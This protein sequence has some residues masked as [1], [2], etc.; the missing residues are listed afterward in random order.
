MEKRQIRLSNDYKADVK[1]DKVQLGVSVAEEQAA[2][3]PSEG[4]LQGERAAA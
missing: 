2:Q 1:V 4:G 3:R